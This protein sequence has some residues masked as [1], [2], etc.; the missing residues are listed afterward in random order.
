MAR[1]GPKSPIGT[2]APKSRQPRR[3]GAAI[4]LDELF[5]QPSARALKAA[6]LASN[7]AG[8]SRDSLLAI[9]DVLADKGTSRSKGERI[10]RMLTRK[11]TRGRRSTLLLVDLENPRRQVGKRQRERDEAI[12]RPLR[13]MAQRAAARFDAVVVWA[14][15]HVPDYNSRTLADVAALYDAARRDSK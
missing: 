5:G 10:A 13:E 7:L 11:P 15:E 3:P 4:T 9:V 12:V 2:K 6:I 14:K 1:T 8:A